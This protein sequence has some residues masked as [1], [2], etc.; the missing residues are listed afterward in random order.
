MR[1]CK[2]PALGG[3]A[4]VCKNCEHVHYRY[5]SCGH[6]HCPICQSIKREQ[7]V[8][9]LR[10]ELYKVPYVHTTFTLPHQLNGLARENPSKIYSLLM[11]VAWKTIKQL[12]K[13]P[14]NIGAIPGMISVLHTFGSDMKYHI[15]VHCLITFGGLSESGEWIYPKRKYK[16]ARYR[17]LSS[18]YKSLFLSGLKKLYTKK[19]IQY[20]QSFEH[21]T[22]GLSK[23]RWVVHNTRPTMDTEVLENYLAR[24]IN[25]VAISNTRL[26]YLKSDKNVEIIYNDYKKQK[27]GKPA[28]KAI[29]TLSPLIAISQILQHLLPPYFQKTRRYGIHSS[30]TKKKI[31]SNIQEILKRND[32][33]VRTLFEI[34]TQLIK[35]TPYSCKKC[36]SEEYYIEQIKPDKK[37]VKQFLTVPTKG[38]A[39]PLTLKIL[40][41]LKKD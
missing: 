24:Y 34:L 35:G 19:D 20:H 8:D 11:R 39:P 28:P 32:Q 31:G 40:S 13:D 9:K 10:T 17:E 4:I 18:T 29:K 30:V 23:K 12:S 22:L 41:K 37:W 25:R 3:T 21:L 1:I 5:Y 16:L 6:S 38:R 15:H 2:S 36:Q 14:K 26:K 33:T 7:W 27:S